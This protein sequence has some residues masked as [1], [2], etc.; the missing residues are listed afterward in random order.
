MKNAARCTE[1]LALLLKEVSRL[2]SS[3]VALQH[4]LCRIKATLRI[5]LQNRDFRLS[6]LTNHHAP[7]NA[8]LLVWHTAEIRIE[9]QLIAALNKFIKIECFRAT[10][11]VLRIVDYAAL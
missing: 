10:I 8:A 2:P 3:T 4:I 7:D 1:E 6:F 5:I 9:R 11:L